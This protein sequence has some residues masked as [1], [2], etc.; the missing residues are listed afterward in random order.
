MAG[1]RI[2]IE[3]V[4]RI[5]GHANVRIDID[6]N[7]NVL[8]ARMMVK[9]LRGFEKILTGMAVESMPL[10]TARICGVCPVSHHLVSAKALDKVYGVEPMQSALKLREAMNFGG[11]IHS[12]TL[13]LF[14][15]SGPDYLLPPG[16]DPAKRNIVGLVGAAPD[17]A[18]KALRLRTLGQKILEIIGG[19]GVHP[20]TAAAGG[21]S[22]SPDEEELK[23]LIEHSD[24]ALK[25]VLELA[26]KI[27]PKLSEFI[28]R[29]PGIMERS[30]DKTYY[31]GT[32]K[33]GKL[34]LYDG[35]LR[36]MDTDGNIV[37]EFEAGDYHGYLEEEPLN[38]SY[39]KPV[40]F[41]DEKGKHI[42]RVNALARVN[43]ADG[44]ET[45]KAQAELEAFRR[46]YDR[47]CH[48]TLMHHY[49][50]LIELI[51]ACERVNELVNDPALSGDRQTPIASTVPQSGI[52]HIEAPRGTLI[53]DY[54]VNADGL[55]EKANLL[56]ATQ[57]NYHSI[58][59]AIK[60]SAQF[61]MGKSD[62]ELKNNIEFFIRTYDPCL[63]CATHAL[64][65]L[66]LVINVYSNGNLQRVIRSM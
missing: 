56:V 30:L 17:I 54:T 63:S 24:E 18:K 27:K 2:N 65:K 3:P 53:H 37:K 40:Y 46:K 57:Q 45:E 49:A 59:N 58:N 5:E 25:L 55:V 21:I 38:W 13:A 29:N 41:K 22:H 15:L 51:Y 8:L 6:D 32:V 39:M 66:P 20:V 48:Y 9:E 16:T 64:G 11:L 19:R 60:Q 28:D 10:V 50:R 33:E 52:A 47:P 62:E 61:F 7:N 34:N 36:V 14:V 31:M 4:T 26:P 12:H 43:V 23:R 42:Y 44:M 35:I 1:R